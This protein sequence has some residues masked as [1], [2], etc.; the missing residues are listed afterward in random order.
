M[1][2]RLAKR[3]GARAHVVHLSAASALPLLSRA[4]E[5]GAQVTVETCPHYLS[6]AAEE[7]ADGATP[8][9]CAPPIREADNRE[10]LW[11][12][13]RE[14]FV[15]QV[16]TDHS[17]STATLKCIGSGDF[18]K[19]WGGIASLQLG[20]AA[21]WTGARARGATL[22]HV[23]RWMCAG[24]AALIGLVGKKG[25]IAPGADA[26]LAAFDPEAVM[27][28]SA[29]RLE[30]KNKVTPYEGRKLHG[31]VRRTWLRGE[32]IYEAGAFVGAPRGGLLA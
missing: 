9:K 2:L 4:R 10:A 1:V 6:F 31:V 26:D 32:T 27:A 15:D 18:T 11:G 23:V 17:P 7:I 19:A 13:L 3:H 8:F 30:H 16:V 29:S 12:A 22:E 14:G 20:L 28:V 24:P 21:V 25:V 5:E